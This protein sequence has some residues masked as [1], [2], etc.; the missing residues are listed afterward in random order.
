MADLVLIVHA[1]AT[2]LMTGLVWFV[3][4]VH[5]P[6]FARVGEAQF[7][8]YEHH[9]TRRASWIIAPLMIAELATAVL[10]AWPGIGVVEPTMAWGGLGLVAV[11]W[12]STF[13]VQVPIHRRLEK[14]HDTGDIRR[15]VSTN[16]I[17]TIAWS[18]RA[19]LAVMM[20]MPR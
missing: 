8:E 13:F 4:V 9:H 17:R 11:I 12:L 16:W 5:Y 1:L 6:L 3:Q 18:A 20:L 15:L 14:R 7:V 19:V 10:I 2:T